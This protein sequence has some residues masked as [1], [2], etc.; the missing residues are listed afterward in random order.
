MLQQ[1]K[2]IVIKTIT[3]GES[4]LVVKM[5]TEELGMQSYLVKGRRKGGEKSNIEYRTLNDEYRR[6]RT[7][8]RSEGL[9]ADS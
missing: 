1:T 6:R 9:Q 3:Y 8:L 2:G 4:G 5:F 7:G